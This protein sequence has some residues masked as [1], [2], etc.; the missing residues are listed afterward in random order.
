M[1][2]SKGLKNVFEIAVV[3]EQ[4]AFKPLKSYCMDKNKY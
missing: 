3:S 4:S 2:F 1:G